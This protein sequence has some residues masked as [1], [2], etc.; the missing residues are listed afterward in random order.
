M[1]KIQKKTLQQ[2][3]LKN[4]KIHGQDQSRK[5]FINLI[6]TY[7]TPLVCVQGPLDISLLSVQYID[8]VIY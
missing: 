7:G 3:T 2:K 6:K 1:Q 4:I 5:V 8:I